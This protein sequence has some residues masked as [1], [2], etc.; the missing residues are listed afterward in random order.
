M[1]FPIFFGPL[2][3]F[4]V[5]DYLTL[6]I[7]VPGI[8]LSVIAQI[9]VKTTF[10]KYSEV[11]SEK[12]LTGSEVARKILRHAGVSE[13]T[14]VPGRGSLTDNFNPKTG[15]ITLS[16]DV[17]GSSSVA[18]AGVAAHE[19]GHA[20]QYE[21]GYIPFKIRSAMV[22]VTNIGT[23]AALPLALVGI[24]IEML[25]GEGGFGT[26]LIA[27]GIFLYSLSALFALITLPVEIN[28]SSRAK[29]ILQS[30]GILS[31][32]ETAMAGKVLGAAAWTYVASLVISLL[33]LFRFL[34][35]IATLRGGRRR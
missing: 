34:L 28:A 15:M 1:F 13:V 31:Q 4:Y 9:R 22:G 33:Y 24:F 10:A 7:I 8:I 14:V 32:K 11:M 19:V 16:Q 27:I 18:A 5:L 17:F 30:T 26:V 2:W 25:A 23:F 29:K 3:I 21:K 6:I 12:G 35:I 20:I